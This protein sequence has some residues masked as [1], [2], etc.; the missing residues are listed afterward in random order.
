MH[1]GRWKE[2][3]I[4]AVSSLLFM[5][6]I[7][8]L[9][10][11]LSIKRTRLHDST[12]T[13][14]FY[15]WRSEKWKLSFF[16]CLV[17]VVL[18]SLEKC[19]ADPLYIVPC[20]KNETLVPFVIYINYLQMTESSF[21]KCSQKC[22]KKKLRPWFLSL[23]VGFVLFREVYVMLKWWKARTQSSCKMK[24]RYFYSKEEK[25]FLVDGAILCTIP[26]FYQWR[27]GGCKCSH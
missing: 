4:L 11:I 15:F 22:F 26:L 12:E 25:N 2:V 13:D 1:N 9:L 18:W 7:C 14:V 19:C 24:Y 21:F 23:S 5:S 27:T 17:Y 10:F 6:F 16:I 8:H 3:Y 20:L